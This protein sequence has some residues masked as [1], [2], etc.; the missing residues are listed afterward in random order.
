MKPAAAAISAMATPS[1]PRS[2]NI[3]DAVSTKAAR[4]AAACARETLAKSSSP[5]WSAP[6][7]AAR[8]PRTGR[9][10]A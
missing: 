1:Y 3:L 6:P 7:S 5:D 10:R 2:R 4:L 8:I 9:H